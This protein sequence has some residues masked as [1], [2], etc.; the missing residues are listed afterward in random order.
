M[1]SAPEQGAA[2]ARPASIARICAW[3]AI[4]ATLA[5]A[6]VFRV[7]GLGHL[8]G[9]NGDEAW[10]GVLAEKIAAGASASWR[11]PTGNLP[12]PFQLGL[13]LLLQPFFDP[14]FALLRL[15]SLLSSIAAMGLGWWIVR[16]FFGAG[17]G[18]IAL[19]LLATMPVTIAYARFGWDPS[20]VPLIGLAA[21]GCAL[22]NR[23]LLC[24]IAFAIALVT[25]ATSIFIAPFLT[26]AL[27]GA[28]REQEGWRPALRHAGLFSLLLI[29]ALAVMTVTI[30]GG[31]ASVQP[32]AIAERL[33][34]PRQWIAFLMLYGRLL[35]GDTVYM[36]VAGTGFGALRP[37]VDVTTMVLLCGL[38]ALGLRSLSRRGFG[39]EAGV[40]AGWLATLLGFFLVAGN[41]AIMPHFERYAMCLIA[42]ST[43]ALAVLAREIGGRR[44]RLTFP[45]AATALI[46]A[47][48]LA[49][50][51]Q[52]YIRALEMSGSLSHRAFQTGPV[53][54]KQEAFDAILAESGGRPTGVMAE[55]W[56]LAWPI[57][58]LA[59]GHAID[60]T[61]VSTLPPGPVV[62]GRLWLTFAG[63]ELDRRLAATPGTVLRQTI[64]GTG[65]PALLH[66]WRS[67]RSSHSPMRATN[68]SG[69]SASARRA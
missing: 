45:V 42:P 52:H 40:V 57:A 44:E 60:V 15:P 29:L 24:A 12:G 11:T 8:P 66:L 64:A 43:L 6:L 5:L 55:D 4:G 69:E 23:P 19:L 32:A 9:I 68:Q 16:H 67:A 18:L 51:W 25:H 2:G 17:A 30:S 10:Y 41:G 35:S 46:A 28:A 1:D 14:D 59:A 56:W 54:P 21:A 22:A 7:I 3:T 53:E 61:D 50:F 36:F 63:S 47:L 20:H 58:Y 38:T 65:R 48:L 37:L 33:A 13:L 62:P 27:L 49:G 31:N 26:L 34:D 39:R